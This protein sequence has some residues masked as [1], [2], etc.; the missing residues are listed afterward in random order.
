MYSKIVEGCFHGWYICV[1]SAVESD[2]DIGRFR[3]LTYRKTIIKT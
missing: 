3:C 2:P 1:H